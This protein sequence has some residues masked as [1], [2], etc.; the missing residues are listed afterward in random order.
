[1]QPQSTASDSPKPGF[2]S[3]IFGGLRARWR[4]IFAKDEAPNIYPFF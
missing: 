1:M 2:F 4:R 3:R